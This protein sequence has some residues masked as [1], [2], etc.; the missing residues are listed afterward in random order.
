M[1]RVV[2]TIGDVCAQRQE[3]DGEDAIPKG[4]RYN[5]GEQL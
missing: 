3:V 1:R 5:C 4:R 2:E